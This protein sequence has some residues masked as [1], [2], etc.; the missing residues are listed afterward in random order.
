MYEKQ[1]MKNNNFSKISDILN[2]SVLA[3]QKLG[4]AFD[5]CMLFDF[6]KN[7]VGKRFEKFSVPYDLKGAVLF[8]SV[9][10]PAIIQ[11]LSFYKAD[12]IKKYAPYAKGL[13][14]KIVDVRFD[15]KNWGNIKK[16]GQ[17]DAFDVDTPDVY[18]EDD[19]EG[20]ILDEQE[21]SEFKQLQK[22]ISDIDFLPETLKEKTYTNAK[23]SY[24]AQKLRKDWKKS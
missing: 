5:K 10:S 20:V 12:I 24:K 7:V 6:W 15:Y 11:E 8:V 21:E 4:Q 9:S 1:S 14:F 13:N 17:S 23:K 16:G 18:S 2:E 19:F 3:N 22:N